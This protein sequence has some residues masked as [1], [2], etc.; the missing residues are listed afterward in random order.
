LHKTGLIVA[1]DK[2][3]GI[4][5]N[6]SIPWNLKKDMK[7]F[8]ERTSNTKDPTK[9]N[10]VVMGRRCWESIPEKFRPL[11][12]RLN[13]VISRTLPEH[14][15]ESLIISNNFDEIMKELLCGQLSANVER[16]WNIG[17]G[18]IYKLALEKGFVDWILM[19][20]IQTD[21]GADVFLHGI[22]WNHFVE[23]E[24][25]RSDV[26]SENELEFSFHSYRYIE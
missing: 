6:G 22:D 7:H 17:G 3:L 1:V 14:R 21:F 16:V 9:V 11:K 8:V 4:A 26:M 12:N 18:E 13:V 19:T 23:D 2:N 25:A 24:S 10:A 20:R 5:K 15:D